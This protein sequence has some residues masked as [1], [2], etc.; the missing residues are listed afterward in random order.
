MYPSATNASARFD[1]YARNLAILTEYWRASRKCAAVMHFCG[2]GYSRSDPPRG[3]T[4][5]HFIDIQNLEF[6][7]HFY[8][9]LKSAFNPVGIMVELW[10][11]HFPTGTVLEVPIHLTNDRDADW[12]G[13]LT[14]TLTVDDSIVS[15]ETLP[16]EMDAL[17]TTVLNGHLAMP[18]FQG[19]AAMWQ[20]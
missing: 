12:K 11:D 15:R 20:R 3:Q 1:I 4:S 16:A 14:L 19:I 17:G 6:E 7:P 13:D 18:N 10:K 9:Y 2:L 5:D 8:E